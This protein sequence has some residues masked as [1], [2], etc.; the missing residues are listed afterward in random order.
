MEALVAADMRI[1]A[2]PGTSPH[3]L[4]PEHIR[5]TG[6]TAVHTDL[7]CHVVRVIL[8]QASH[9]SQQHS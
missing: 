1:C 6:L 7:H 3:C 5:V 8:A 2:A 4:G 9:C